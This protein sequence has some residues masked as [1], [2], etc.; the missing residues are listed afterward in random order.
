MVKLAIALV[1]RGVWPRKVE[2]SQNETCPVGFPEPERLDDTV[3]VN[4][5]VFDPGGGTDD[6]RVV[7]VGPACTFWTNIALPV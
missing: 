7:V 6:F 1:L 3:A 2:P 4:V 5:T